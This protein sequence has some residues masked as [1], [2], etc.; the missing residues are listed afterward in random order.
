MTPCWRCCLRSLLVWNCLY[1]W[2]FGWLL[3]FIKPTS[4]T[5]ACVECVYRVVCI[6]H[7]QP[8]CV[9]ETVTQDVL[10][11]N[12]DDADETRTV[13][14]GTVNDDVAPS[15][16]YFRVSF[17]VL[18]FF[19]FDFVEPFCFTP[20]I[21]RMRVTDAWNRHVERTRETDVLCNNTD[22]RLCDK[23]GWI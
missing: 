4:V 11:N 2:L 19:L 23:D 5:D 1:V 21:Y 20:R 7:V 14:F 13:E 15:W 6:G 12:A 9:T 8:M 22:E 18:N 16:G 10:C 17:F 3:G